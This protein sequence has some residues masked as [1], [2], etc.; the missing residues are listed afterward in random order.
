MLAPELLHPFALVEGELEVHGK[1]YGNL[2]EV[3]GEWQVGGGRR[4]YDPESFFSLRR[5]SSSAIVGI[6]RRAIRWQGALPSHSCRGWMGATW[7]GK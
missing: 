4:G 3:M 5:F 1:L 7:I 2:L 6:P